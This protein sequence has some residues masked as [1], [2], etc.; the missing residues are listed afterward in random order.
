MRRT[1]PRNNHS[2]SRRSYQICMRLEPGAACGQ[3]PAGLTVLP[4]HRRP[5]PPLA[6]VSRRRKTL[7]I[8]LTC[9]TYRRR[10]VRTC[11]NACRNCLSSLAIQAARTSCIDVELL[12]KSDADIAPQQVRP[13]RR[14]AGPS[15]KPRLQ[16][17]APGLAPPSRC[18][19]S[20]R[21]LNFATDGGSG[22]WR[23]CR[24]STQRSP[25]VKVRLT[26]RTWLK[27]SDTQVAPV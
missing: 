2:H 23:Q 17:K 21:H 19:D 11:A 18:S 12:M 25:L 16:Q 22:S 24:L 26:G 8:V 5:S 1:W 13:T 3:E 7:C 14:F 15:V 9:C 27:R 4:R 10:S 20:S 6:C